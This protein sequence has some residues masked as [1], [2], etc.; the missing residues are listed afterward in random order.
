MLTAP[1][2]RGDRIH[3]AIH[4]TNGERVFEGLA[5]VRDD[6]ARWGLR[7]V[8]RLGAVPIRAE[9]SF[10]SGRLRTAVAE[11]R[12]RVVQ[13]ARPR[14]MESAGARREVKRRAPAEEV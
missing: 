10:S 11:S 5:E 9:G 14:L 3:I 4:L 12:Q 7:A 8:R 13:S 1:E 2:E 6:G